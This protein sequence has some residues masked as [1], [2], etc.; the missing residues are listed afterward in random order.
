MKNEELIETAKRVVPRQLPAGADRAW[1]TARAAASRTSTGRSYLDLC[2]GIAVVSVG[3][4]HPRLARAIGEQAARL[5][6]TSNLFYNQRAIELAQRAA[7]R[8]GVRRASSSATA[9]PRPTRR[10]SSWRGATSTTAAR[11]QRIEIVVAFEGSFH[12]RTMGALSADRPGQ[13]PRGLGPARA[14]RAPRRRTAT[15]PALERRDHRAHG[16]GDARA[17]PGRGRRAR[18][19]PTGTC[20]ARAQA[21]RRARRAADLRRGADRH[22]PHRALHAAASTAA[23]MP[24]ACALAKGIAG[25][26]P[27]RRDGRRRESSRT[28]CRRARMPSTFGGNPLALRGG[29]RRAA[30]ISTRSSWLE[31]ADA[32]G[33]Y[34]GDD[35]AR[36]GAS[37]PADGARR[38]AAACCAALSSRRRSNPA[39]SLARVREQGVLLSLAG[40]NV[41]RF[42]PPLV[43][44]ARRDRRGRGDRRARARSKRRDASERRDVMPRHFLTLLDLTP[45]EL[46]ALLER[47]ARAQ[48]HA[49]RPSIRTPLAGKSVAHG[50]REGLDAHARLVRGRRC[51]SSAATPSTSPAR[52]AARPR[53]A[54]RDTARVL[55]ALLHAVVLRTFGH[56]RVE[57]LA[58]TR[59]RAG[60]QRRSPTCSTRARCSRI[61]MT[62]IEHRRQAALDGLARRLDRRRQQH[63]ALVDRGGR[64][65]RLRSGAGLSRRATS[66]DAGVLGAGARAGAARITRDPRPGRGGA[67]RRTWSRPTSGPRWARRTRPRRAAG[68]RRL[69]R[70]RAR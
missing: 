35:A 57:K 41:V 23:S 64:A 61:C 28:R 31:N 36:L 45:A 39:A 49:R 66:P 13:V 1:S 25:R 9:A 33:A 17:D 46:A 29:A 26:L 8:T 5:M 63:G 65:P 50:V 12:G 6:H 67:R 54:A 10:C 62:V 7:A 27:D 38:A 60:D 18:R 22:R 43:R 56:E 11:T 24:D 4:G 42:A 47:A 40:G 32:T 68:V 52:H 55:V 58:R 69:L 37:M 3:H 21:V 2:A 51:T 16:R 14:G 15:S 20:R 44:H 53:R 34:L 48:A 19:P 59:P 30:T 70:R